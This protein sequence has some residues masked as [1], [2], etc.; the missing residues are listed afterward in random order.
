MLLLTLVTDSV[1]CVA[2]N[3]AEDR[4]A[5]DR[6]FRIGQKRNVV[7]FRF[8][9]A[10]SIEE[11]M[12]EKQV[13]KDGLRVV[14]E[15]GNSSR[16]FSNNETK[17]LFTLGP[18]EKS[19]VMERLWEKNNNSLKS[20]DDTYGEVPGILGFSRHDQ[21]YAE[22]R[23]DEYNQTQQ[24]QMVSEAV[25]DE[26]EGEE[27]QQHGE[28]AVFRIEPPQKGP[29]PTQQVAKG[30]NHSA[31]VI[32]L[33]L[34]EEDSSVPSFIIKTSTRV[35]TATATIT[36]GGKTTSHIN[37][38][39]LDSDEEEEFE[40]EP[41]AVRIKTAAELAPT[42]G[43][44]R[45]K[46]NRAMVISDDEEEEWTDEPSATSHITATEPSLIL[47]RTA[48]EENIHGHTIAEEGGLDDIQF[49][50]DFSTVKP[51]K[52]RRSSMRRLSLELQ[53]SEELLEYIFE[54]HDGDD[55]ADAEEGDPAAQHDPDATVIE[56]FVAPPHLHVAADD[57]PVQAKKSNEV[58]SYIFEGLDDGVDDE[59]A[60]PPADQADGGEAVEMIELSAV[61]EDGDDDDEPSSVKERDDVPVSR[62]DTVTGRRLSKELHSAPK[63]EGIEYA[64]EDDASDAVNDSKQYVEECESEGWIVKP[65]AA[66][67]NQKIVTAVPL[68]SAKSVEVDSAY[69]TDSQI[70]HQ[71]HARGDSEQRD[72][73]AGY[74]ASILDA[75]AVL[76]GGNAHHSAVNDSCSTIA[77][78]NH[79]A[80]LNATLL[81]E[82]LADSQEEEQQLQHYGRHSGEDEGEVSY[83]HGEDVTMCTD[84]SAFN[85]TRDELFPLIEMRERG[86]IS[87]SRLSRSSTATSVNSGN[88]VGV[89]GSAHEPPTF[90]ALPAEML[91]IEENDAD[92]AASQHQLQNLTAFAMPDLFASPTAGYVAEKKKD[93]EETIRSQ[94]PLPAK[95]AIFSQTPFPACSQV[96]YSSVRI[97]VFSTAKKKRVSFGCE[98]T[99]SDEEEEEEDS[100]DNDDDQEE[101]QP[102][103]GG[104]TQQQQDSYPDSP[105]HVITAACAHQQ[106]DDDGDAV[107]E[108]ATRNA[109][110]SESLYDDSITML[111]NTIY[112]PA[113]NN[114]EEKSES[115]LYLTQ[116]SSCSSGRSVDEEEEDVVYSG[117]GHSLARLEELDETTALDVTEELDTTAVGGESGVIQEAS[118][119]DLSVTCLD[120]AIL[121]CDPEETV[122][123]DSHHVV[124]RS[125]YEENLEETRLDIIHQPSVEQP[126]IPRV[127]HYIESQHENVTNTH[128]LSSSPVKF[129]TP[130]PQLSSHAMRDAKKVVNKRLSFSTALVDVQPAGVSDC[131]ADGTQYVVE[132]R[133]VTGR[134]KRRDKNA[135]NFVVV[136]EAI[137]AGFFDS[138]M[139]DS[140][141]IVPADVV[142]SPL[143]A[144]D[145]IY[146]VMQKVVSYFVV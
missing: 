37:S 138:V 17:D 71:L 22:V 93:I 33:T 45:L 91:A 70:L 119:A 81:A 101:K 73:D 63:Y 20:V 47:H 95:S 100:D 146:V 97:A 108:D 11:K 52:G 109:A 43:F 120:S 50:E 99:S 135:K 90:A 141:V 85:L 10:S 35:T 106:L 16:Y 102:V 42:T 55:G 65:H 68:V 66:D 144:G 28:S 56:E 18:A 14:T 75:S 12:Y 30:S 53:S 129:T 76:I 110:E 3:P 121:Q 59:P 39:V 19:L 89:E 62:A 114:E 117:D 15:S 134:K 84:D 132:E 5:V 139:Q 21:L 140:I 6:A 8:I 24:S 128:A 74:G 40:D 115:K 125:V 72:E 48:E 113:Y 46:K 130:L 126:V 145:R 44:T 123:E 136:E 29:A 67:L 58:L 57:V 96:D 1:D 31:A 54:G 103:N 4:Q 104:D 27:S 9:M 112:L 98:E 32:D 127:H 111:D 124:E 92:A 60:A 137:E 83:C 49:P 87:D 88:F 23:P 69:V 116:Y 64:I 105:V 2:W 34:D 143:T 36:T 41:A 94:S 7:V 107:V 142:N 61:T 82:Y 13:F 25:A 131:G 51:A 38:I 77:F 26:E 79:S 122:L 86:E 80:M 133:N 78:N 118:A